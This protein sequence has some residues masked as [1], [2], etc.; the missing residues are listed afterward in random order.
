VY[1]TTNSNTNFSPCPALQVDPKDVGDNKE[2]QK[3]MG[4][5]NGKA[6]PEAESMLDFLKFLQV[7]IDVSAHQKLDIFSPTE[8]SM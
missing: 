4:F 3:A 6:K 5:A 2:V 7:T 8:A 1:L